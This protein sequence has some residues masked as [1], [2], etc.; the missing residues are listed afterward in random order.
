MRLLWR[1]LV[2]RIVIQRQGGSAAA[3]WLGAEVG[4]DCRILS[5][6]FGSEPWLV[7]IGNRVTISSGVRILT[8]DGVGWLFRSENGRRFRYARV[9]IG[10][11]VFVGIGSIL[12]PGVHIGD[13]CVIGAGSIVTKSVPSGT[14][15]AGNPARFITTF[16]SLEDKSSSWASE[17]DLA[18]YSY[19]SGILRVVDEAYLPDITVPVGVQLPTG[20][21]RLSNE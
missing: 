20:A 11:D 19:K 1:A 15:V 12:M 10:N 13:K 4:D 18:G 9:K 16:D 21:S 7:S 3:R 5:H 14:V 2:L 8:H 6:L 17:D